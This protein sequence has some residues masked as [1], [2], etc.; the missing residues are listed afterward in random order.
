[1]LDARLR[2]LID[3]PLN[4]VGAALARAGLTANALTFAGLA[5]GLAGAG[6]RTG[7]ALEG[8]AGLRQDCG[9]ND[10]TFV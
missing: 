4:R 5:L 1:M 2:P 10:L 7:G 6:G 8:G 3:P 9:Q